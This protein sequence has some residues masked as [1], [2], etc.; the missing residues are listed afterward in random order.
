MDEFLWFFRQK[1]PKNKLN[2][3]TEPDFRKKFRKGL[4]FIRNTQKGPFFE[5]FQIFWKIDSNDFAYSLQEWSTDGSTSFGEN[6]MS[7]KSLE[8]VFF[9]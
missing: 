3:S 4:F 1:I 9:L 2:D 6:R 7:G 8:V 5:V